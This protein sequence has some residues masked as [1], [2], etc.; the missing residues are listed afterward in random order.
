M[1]YVTCLL[2]L[3]KNTIL[4][5]AFPEHVT[6]FSRE[7]SCFWRFPFKGLLLYVT[8]LSVLQHIT[9]LKY[10]IRARHII[11]VIYHCTSLTN[12]LL[13]HV[14]TMPNCYRYTSLNSKMLLLYITTHSA[15]LHITIVRYNIVKRHF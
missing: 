14:T 15:L 9:K 12:V 3:L 11:E 2:A 10:N 1:L 13:L 6:T 7:V 4:P 5:V 8:S